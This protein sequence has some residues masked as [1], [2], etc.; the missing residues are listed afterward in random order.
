MTEPTPPPTPP[1]LAEQRAQQYASAKRNLA[2][3]LCIAC[4]VIALLPPRKL[5][6]YTLALGGIWIASANHVSGIRS[7]RT[8]FQRLSEP[9]PQ[10]GPSERYQEMQRQLRERG[11]RGR[12][13]EKGVVEKIWMG[14][15]GEDWKARRAER[16]KEV[17]QSGEGYGTLIMDQIKEVW[18]GKKKAEDGEGGDGKTDDAASKS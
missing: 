15:Q 13:K 11:I 17:L 6:L 16:E 3:G 7:G 14:D 9:A 4:P 5:D 12:E 10:S 1:S 2:I 8:I 18:T